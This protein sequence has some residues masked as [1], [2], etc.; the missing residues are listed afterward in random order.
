MVWLIINSRWAVPG[1][2]AAAAAVVATAGVVCSG[3]HCEVMCSEC[4]S[5]LYYCI[6]AAILSDDLCQAYM[7]TRL[8]VFTELLAS[9]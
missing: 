3:F 4:D 9:V 7:S 8:H 6:G 2:H 1:V 5:V